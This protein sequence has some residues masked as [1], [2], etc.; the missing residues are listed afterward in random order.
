M[1]WWRNADELT[2]LKDKADLSLDDKF[3]EK[4]STS[5][6][7][8]ERMRLFIKPTLMVFNI[9]VFNAV[10]NITMKDFHWTSNEISFWVERV[11]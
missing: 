9:Q 3:L 4:L 1:G 10:S 5:L 2:R 8:Y 11:C 7:I 6:G